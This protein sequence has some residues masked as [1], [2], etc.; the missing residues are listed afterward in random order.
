M[1]FSDKDQQYVVNLVDQ[2]LWEIMIPHVQAQVIYVVLSLQL[3][4][5]RPQK[6]SGKLVGFEL[7]QLSL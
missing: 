2:M 7:S 5:D 3:I 1:G 4:I 6:L